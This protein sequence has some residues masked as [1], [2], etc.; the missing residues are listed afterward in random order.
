[1]SAHDIAARRKK[2]FRH[3]TD[4]KHAFPIADNL[5]KRDF[6]VDEP[7]RV[8][9]TDITYVWTREGWLYLAAIVDLYSRATAAWAMSAIIGRKLCL[10]ALALAVAARRPPPGLIHHSDRGSRYASGDYR[11]ALDVNKMLCSMS[12]K[13]DCWDNAV[14]ESFWCTIKAELIHDVDFALRAAAEQVIFEYLEVF[15][16]RRRRHS[17]IGYRTPV[18]QEEIYEAARQTTA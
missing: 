14:A 15:H 3:T 5:L 7:T 9:V 16:H 13:G 17:R 4:S 8:W 18:Q 6:H 10:D 12:R 1:M 2:R 11:R